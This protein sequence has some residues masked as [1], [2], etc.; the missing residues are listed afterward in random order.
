MKRAAAHKTRPDKGRDWRTPEGD[1]V[2]CLEKIKVLEE[3][4]D[5]IRQMC[6]DALEDAVLMGCSEDQFREV[7]QNLID[8]LHNP[9][10]KK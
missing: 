3:N 1:P 5:E 9:Y 4:I 7:L 2:S 6:Q 8:S 10:R